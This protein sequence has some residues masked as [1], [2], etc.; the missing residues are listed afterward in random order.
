MKVTGDRIVPGSS[1]R[2]PF[3][4]ETLPAAKK[5]D[6]N[7]PPKPI[8]HAKGV[9]IP[10]TKLQVPGEASKS[11]AAKSSSG[12]EALSLLANQKRPLPAKSADD[13]QQEEPALKKVRKEN[14][15]ALPE[16]SEDVLVASFAGPSITVC[17][18]AV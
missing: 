10:E 17:S 16:V 18:L 4:L 7:Q 15:L 9:A 8:S 13:K 2:T 11:T 5:I 3:S 6:E 1:I 12:A 14:D